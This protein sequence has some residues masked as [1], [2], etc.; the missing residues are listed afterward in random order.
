MTIDEEGEGAQRSRIPAVPETAP[1]SEALAQTVAEAYV[2][3]LKEEMPER[4]KAL[5]E[6]IKRLE[7]GPKKPG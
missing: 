4:M 6:S 2:D 5:I 3:V 7:A 1:L